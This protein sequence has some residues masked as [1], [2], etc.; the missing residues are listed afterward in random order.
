MRDGAVLDSWMWHKIL[1]G[2]VP[3]EAATLL[4]FEDLHLPK[5]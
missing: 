2:D 5:P 4:F 3:C 1:H